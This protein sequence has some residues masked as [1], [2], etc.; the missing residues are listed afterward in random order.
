LSG[1]RVGLKFALGSPFSS[2]VYTVVDGP[3]AKVENHQIFKY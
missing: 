1:S 2:V 3:V